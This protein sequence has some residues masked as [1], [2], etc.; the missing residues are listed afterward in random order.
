ME[1]IRG[2]TTIVV[3]KIAAGP[4]GS[5]NQLYIHAAWGRPLTRPYALALTAA[6]WQHYG[7]APEIYAG[8]DGLAIL[9]PDDHDINIEQLLDVV[10]SDNL[11]ELLRQTLESSTYYGARFRESAGCA[12]LITRSAMGRRL[13]LWLSRVRAQELMEAV[14]QY[15]DFPISL[16]AWRTCCQ[17]EFDLPNLCNQIDLLHA[18]N[19]AIAQAHTQH[20]S[21]FAQGE[22]WRH[23]NA[24]VYRDEPTSN[25]PS[26]LQ[27]DLIR[28]IAHTADL[29]VALPSDLVIDSDSK[30]QRL[31]P[32][33]AP[34][35]VSELLDWLDER[36]FMTLSEWQKLCET[37]DIDPTPIAHQFTQNRDDGVHN[38]LVC[39]HNESSNLSA[40][41][42]Y[43][44]PPTTKETV[45]PIEDFIA[46]WLQFH[47]PI[48]VDQLQSELGILGTDSIE[49][50]LT[51]LALKKTIV[52]GQIVEE[53]DKECVCDL[54]N[55][56]MIVRRLRTYRSESFEPVPL[57]FITLHTAQL[58][59]VTDSIHGYEGLSEVLARIS[60]YPAAAELWESDIL[61]AR[62]QP[63]DPTW[64][65]QMASSDALC[66]I[67]S[68]G[69][70]VSILHP[71]EIDLYRIE[72]QQSKIVPPDEGRYTLDALRKITGLSARGLYEELWA[73]VW[74]GAVTSDTLS[75]LRTAITSGYKA[76]SS[77]Y[78]DNSRRWR[79]N[80]SRRE[81]NPPR[82]GRWYRTPNTV[83]ATPMEVEELGKER[84]ILLLGRYPVL[85]REL[86]ER[87]CSTLRW[88]QLFRSLRL[89]E[90]SGEVI[91]G[92]FYEDIRGLQFTTKKNLTF[93]KNS[94]VTPF[95]LNACDPSSMCGLN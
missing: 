9:T 27:D 52:R 13:P 57:E 17:D 48:S 34:Q 43:N 7:F 64:V 31:H 71:T 79:R 77:Q 36:G 56:E 19:I 87:E 25:R 73:E 40:H 4:Y 15:T 23:I 16:E 65:D 28:D 6:A 12:L 41:F 95:W 44:T 45:P 90:L 20:P 84:V 10:R 74:T 50:S 81:P 1:Q 2:V 91:S 86:L 22:S 49:K 47:G 76:P 72:D 37:N 62:V 70:Q 67:G 18:N 29:L 66:W 75:T 53:L 85:F 39:H 63:Y 83:T 42:H 21:P 5:G 80:R 94:D 30:L 59:S 26:S 82:S 32:D 89:M 58:Q 51:K 69:K 54:R 61:P 38:P 68:P 60:C 55:Y 14:A 3:E 33:Y 46:L 24:N 88:N 11:S 8:N 92:S 35:T 78:G 93:L